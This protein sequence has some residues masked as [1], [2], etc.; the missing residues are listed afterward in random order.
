MGYILPVPFYQYQDYQQRVTPEKQNPY[1]I[2]RP[3]KVILNSSYKNI[4]KEEDIHFKYSNR[5][6][7]L[8]MPRLTHKSHKNEKIYSELTGKGKHFNESV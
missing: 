2:E 5:S 8:H 4:E 3:Y 1:F 7:E 6:N